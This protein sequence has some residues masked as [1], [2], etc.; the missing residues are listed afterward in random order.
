MCQNVIADLIVVKITLQQIGRQIF[1]QTELV[2]F[3][4]HRSILKSYKLK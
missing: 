3:K 1:N 4:V 2:E